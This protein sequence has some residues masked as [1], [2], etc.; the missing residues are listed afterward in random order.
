[1]TPEARA[2]A[3]AALAAAGG[4][5]IPVLCDEVLAALSP[6]DGDLILDGT[7]GAGGYSRA[8]LAAAECN[9]IGLDRDPDALAEASVWAPVFGDRLSLVQGTFG[10]MDQ[11]AADF[12][13]VTGIVLDIG[14]S[15]MQLDRA[16]RGFSFLRDGHL[17]PIRR[18]TPIPCACPCGRRR[19]R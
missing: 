12:P 15:S 8:I 4:D 3:D 16:R 7:F 18:R 10:T 17:L 13:Q 19:A 9:V 5:H 1:V 2:A 14:V 11:T 6:S